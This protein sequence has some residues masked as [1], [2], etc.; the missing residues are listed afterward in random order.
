MALINANINE[1]CSQLK[2]KI[3]K[4]LKTLY[5]IK[6]NRQNIYELIE[7]F[8]QNFGTLFKLND[9]KMI[10]EKGLNFDSC[11]IV[12]EESIENISTKI[13]YNLENKLFKCDF[14]D[15]IKS[16]KTKNNLNA[17][18]K[19]VH[20][21]I[22]LKCV[23][24][25][26]KYETNAKK[27]LNNHNLIHLEEKNFK[28]HFQNCNQVFKQRSTLNAHK[29]IHSNEK[30]FVCDW[31][32][33]HMKFR[34]KIHLIKHKNIVH[35]KIKLFDCTYEG[36][37]QRFNSKYRKEIHLHNH[38]GEKPFVCRYSNCNKSFYS[39]YN[40]NRQVKIH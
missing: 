14:E 36:C 7:F 5:E 33:C 38:F 27:Y 35:L 16:Y 15:C 21:S 31:N 12:F 19:Y 32:Q 40:L 13:N 37:D 17:H 6:R 24:P 20:S 23:W 10:V 8:K 30:K 4:S 25:Q 1:T 26:C 11:K 39:K 2:L 18:K 22:K 29:K 9:K 3:S 28:C 34:Q